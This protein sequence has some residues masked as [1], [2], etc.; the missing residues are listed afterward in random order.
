MSRAGMQTN[1]FE[2]KYVIDEHIAAAIRRYVL[3][4]LEPDEHTDPRGGVG[5]PV[6]SLYLDSSDLALCRQTLSGKKNRFKL[7]IRFYD[8]DPDSPVFFEIKRRVNDVI[9]KQR[10]I[11]Y[12]ASVPRFLAGATLDQR[13]LVKDDPKNYKA[14]FDFCELRNELTAGPAAYTSYEREAYE[15]PDSNQYRV[16]FD[17]NLMAGSYRGQL[18]VA[19]LLRWARPQIDGVVLELKFNGRFPDWMADLVRLFNLQRTSLPKYVECVTVIDGS[20]LRHLGRRARSPD[21][22][23]F[24]R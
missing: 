21:I 14:L 24:A 12:R 20:P 13:D 10:A 11:V 6:H 22:L 9:M 16:T 23:P 1:R 3:Q 15:P 2:L 5:Y 4:Y 19:D 18:S 7:R 17:R 8:D